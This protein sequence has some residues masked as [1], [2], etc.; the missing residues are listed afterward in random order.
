[1]DVEVFGA[2]ALAAQPDASLGDEGGGN[3]PG[4][5]DGGALGAV[6]TGGREAFAAAAGDAEAA[7]VGDDGTLEAVADGEPVL[8]GLL[9]I[10]LNIEGVLILAACGGAG[11]V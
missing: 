6:D 11:V 8:I 4:V 10:H 1:S 2:V 9:V 3:Q 5:V 7:G